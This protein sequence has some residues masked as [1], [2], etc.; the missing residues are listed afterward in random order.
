MVILRL[1]YTFLGPDELTG[2]WTDQSYLLSL[3]SIEF[4][5]TAHIWISA[6]FVGFCILLIN[7]IIRSNQAYDENNYLAGFVF[8][9]LTHSSN[10]F[11]VVSGGLIATT[12][13]LIGIHLILSHIKQR[14]S[15]ENIF[16]TGV[17][18]GLAVL[19]YSPFMIF[20][21]L[22]LL[23][24]IFFT[25]T[26]P[27]RYMLSAFGFTF[28]F[29]IL[30]SMSLYGK[31]PMDFGFFFMQLF[32]GEIRELYSVN[33]IFLLIPLLLSLFKLVTSFSGIAMTNHQI[34]VQRVMFIN[35]LAMIFV[36]FA[37][38]EGKGFLWLLTIPATYFF[39]KSLLEINK[40]WV[41]SVIFILWL[42]LL[43]NPYLLAA[44]L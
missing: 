37:D 35:F 22:T 40:K 36:F 42:A 30:W 33:Y 18:I 3:F 2:L 4:S 16:F 21:P 8:L 43:I 15:E 11:F 34:H 10:Q 39:S 7:H 14:A 1:L 32:K 29:L 12:C 23:I 9:I 24:Y 27:R 41:R 19:F 31:E 17:L 44:D 20:L 38:S 25:R 26:I 5:R 13:L 6:F 28:P